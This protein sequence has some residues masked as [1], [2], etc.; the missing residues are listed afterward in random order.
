M[1][2]YV[3]LLGAYVAIAAAGVAMYSPFL[4]G[5]PSPLAALDASVPLLQAGLSVMGGLCLGGAFVGSTVSA[6][7]TPEQRLLETGEMQQADD[8]VP[9]LTLAAQQPVAGK[10]ARKALDQLHEMERRHDR[11]MRALAAS[12]AEGSL[13]YERF[14][15]AVAQVEHTI[16]RNCAWLCNKV[17]AFDGRDYKRVSSVPVQPGSENSARAEQLA[18]YENN[19]TEITGILDANDRLLVELSRLED[20]LSDLGDDASRSNNESVL[21][22]IQTLVEQTKH[23]RM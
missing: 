7:R 10:H 20:E 1:M 4:L 11:V 8:V 5:L 2:K 19:L 17:Q 14:E 6:L 13:S 3:K 9:E 15:A 21:D 16:V 22:E 23:Y 18:L 12:F